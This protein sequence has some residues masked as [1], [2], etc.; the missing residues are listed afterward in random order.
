MIQCS[1]LSNGIRVITDKMEGVR[2][3]SLGVWVNAGSVFEQAAVSGCSH[4]IEHMLFKGTSRRSARDIAVEMDAI[5]GSMNAFT[6]KECTCYYVKVL[7]DKTETAVDMLADVLL[8][9]KLAKEDIEREKGVVLE[10]IGMTEDSPEDLVFEKAAQTFF[11]DTPLQ[12]PILGT[13][14]TVS[15]LQRDAL[16]AYMVEH[17]GSGDLVI[18]C[19]GS[20]EREKLIE[21][22]ERGFAEAKKTHKHEPP[23]VVRVEEKQFCFVQKDVEQVHTCLTFPGTSLVKEGEGYAM[24]ILSNIL[25]GSMSSRLFQSIREELGLAYSVYSYPISY[26]G[27]GSFSLY[28]GSGEK[29]APKVLELMLGELTKILSEGVPK[30]EFSRAKEQLKGNYLLSME[31]SGAHMNAIGKQL[32]LLD[33]EY[34]VESTL[35]RIECV[36]MEQMEALAQSLFSAQAL[37][38][39]AVGRIKNVQ[40]PM[41][42]NIERWW[43]Q[44]GQT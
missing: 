2:S 38:L 6:A 17:Y 26:R 44:H 3:V 12:R 24:Q 18:A 30:D 25:G 34:S 19:A 14:E 43:T 36:T 32:L 28:A 9:S 7:D 22:L 20:F 21:L 41:Q 4:F 31:S 10:E 11:R 23:K 40:K 1:R 5:G 29:Q 16:C 37:T 8:H 15:S 35:S 33:E 39:T 42:D 13:A 27:T